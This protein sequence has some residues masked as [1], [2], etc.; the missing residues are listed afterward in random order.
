[1]VNPGELGDTSVVDKVKELTGGGSTYAIDTTAVASV[2]K[3]AAQAL[4]PRA[5]W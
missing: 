3:Q 1:M 4:G 2:I 5:S